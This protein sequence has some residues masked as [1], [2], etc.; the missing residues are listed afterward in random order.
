VRRLPPDLLTQFPD[1][2]WLHSIRNCTEPSEGSSRNRHTGRGKLSHFGHSQEAHSAFGSGRQ[3]GDTSF[4]CQSELVSVRA[5]RLK[6]ARGPWRCAHFSREIFGLRE[7][8]RVRFR[9]VP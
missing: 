1:V 5:I 3:F 7:G 4:T 6:T 2:L 9:V 8:Q